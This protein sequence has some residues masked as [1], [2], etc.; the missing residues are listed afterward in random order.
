[1]TAN[2]GASNVA[3]MHSSFSPAAH[4]FHSPS[5]DANHDPIR[6]T[7]ALGIWIFLAAEHRTEHGRAGDALNHHG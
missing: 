4:N 1:M 3:W 7:S 2:R 6:S 5:D